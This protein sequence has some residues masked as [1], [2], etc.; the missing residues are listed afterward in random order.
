V[1]V[2]IDTE[3]GLTPGEWA[4]LGILCEGPAHGFGIARRLV[5]TA[6][7]GQVWTMNRPAVYRAIR[8]LAASDLIL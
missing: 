3:R 4:V 1:G 7:I 6:T 8:D 5:E 2:T